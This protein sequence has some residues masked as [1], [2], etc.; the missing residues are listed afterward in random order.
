MKY[1]LR[2]LMVAVLLMPPL[3][4]VTV[5]LTRLVHEAPWRNVMIDPLPKDF[6]LPHYRSDV[7]SAG[8]PDLEFELPNS[9]EPAPS[10]PK[11]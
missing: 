1:S 4:A 6:D 3:I 8:A 10:P 11:P 7:T 5:W 9:Q 2:S